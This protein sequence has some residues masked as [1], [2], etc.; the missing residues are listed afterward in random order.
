MS[1]PRGDQHLVGWAGGP[2][3]VGPRLDRPAPLAAPEAGRR[4]ADAS[5]G[6]SSPLVMTVRQPRI[7]AARASIVL[8]PAPPRFLDNAVQEIQPHESAGAWASREFLG[9]Q[10]QVI[11]SR[12]VASRVVEKLGLQSDADFLGLPPGTPPADLASVDAAGRLLGVLSVHPQKETRILHLEVRDVVPERAALIANEVAEAYI[13][14]TPGDPP[15]GHPQR[16]AVAGGAAGGAGPEGPPERA[17]GPRLQ[18]RGG[19]PEHLAGEPALHHQ[20]AAGRLQQL[21]HRRAHRDGRPARG[22]WSPW[23]S[24]ASGP[25]GSPLGGAA[26]GGLGLRAGPQAARRAVRDA[27]PSAPSSPCASSPPIP[28]CSPARSSCSCWSRGVHRELE[29]LVQA[30]RT[31][32]AEA[33][34]R[35]RHLVALLEAAKSEAFELN[36]KQLT[37]ERLERDATNDRRL[38]DVVFTRLKDIELSGLVRTSHVR[39]LDRRASLLHAHQ[40]QGPGEPGDGAPGRLRPRGGPGGGAREARRPPASPGGRRGAAA[41]A[42]AGPLPA[43]HD[44]GSG[45]AGRSGICWSP[46]TPTL[47]PPSTAGPSAPT[48]SSPRPRGASRLVVVTS[49]GLDEGKSTLTLNLGA[50]L[51]QSGLRTPDRRCGPAPS[52]AAR[53][54][55]R[56][57]RAWG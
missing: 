28:T 49:G 31:E 20:R 17:G 35:E 52:P 36:R 14:Q 47:P 30:T 56:G 41:R 25:R 43:A 50:A 48:S 2:R 8:D 44:P 39:M 42:A 32:L 37:F 27:E 29:N 16:L 54:P 57:Q 3:R 26:G 10:Q 7:Y 11:L 53:G 19:R 40:S 13:E 51:A 23:S 34:A 9:T 38:H 45:H 1:N 5:P 55:G 15:R 21:A 12:N 24:C 6:W 4:R 18:A 22:G 33:G 46:V